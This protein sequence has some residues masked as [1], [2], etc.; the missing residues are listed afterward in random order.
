[1]HYFS[2]SSR[3]FWSYSSTSD[4]AITPNCSEW[5]SGA[6]LSNGSASK[7]SIFWIK[8]RTACPSFFILAVAFRI[9]LTTTVA[10]QALQSS[11]REMCQNTEFFLV[12]IFP[13]LSWIQ[14]DPVSLGIQTKCVKI[15]TRKNSVFRHF[16]RSGRLYSCHIFYIRCGGEKLCIIL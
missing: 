13:H 7:S 15:R 12:R 2:S 11:R 9:L 10:T 3:V 5:S 16:S 4:D 1:M 6:H 8:S 14:K